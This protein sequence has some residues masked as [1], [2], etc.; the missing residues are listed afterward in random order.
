MRLD[1]S[2][3][4]VRADQ[5][6]EQIMRYFAILTVALSLTMFGCKPKE[7]QLENTVAADDASKI[8]A[9]SSPPIA[10]D[11]VGGADTGTGT[12]TDVGPIDTGSGSDTSA[13]TT[14]EG[15]SYTVKKHEWLTKIALE[16]LGSKS[17]VKDILR[18]NPEI[19]DPNKLHVGQVI[20]LPA[21]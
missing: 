6:R 13:G 11:N 16:Q 21:R 14:G 2:R 20:R 15:R 3:D 10:D 19:K 9:E 12:G 7:P 4:L 8:P 1:R 5:G 17:R 18:L